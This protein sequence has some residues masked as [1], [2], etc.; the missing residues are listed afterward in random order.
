MINAPPLKT[1]DEGSIS[2]TAAAPSSSLD[3]ARATRQLL[4]AQDAETRQIAARA[5]AAACDNWDDDNKITARDAILPLAKMLRA[6]AGEAE[7]GALA[8]R[9]MA[10]NSENQILIAK[11][12]A[13]PP[14]VALLQNGTDVAKENAAGA[15]MFIA[16]R[17][18]NN[19]VA[20][21]QAGAI[22]PLVALLQ[23]GTDKMQE[24][25]AETLGYLAFCD[26]DNG[27]KNKALIAKGVAISASIAKAGAILPL[28]ALLKNGTDGT[29]E[30]A[31]GA[32]QALADF[33][34]DNKV[35]IVSA[36]AIPLLVAL[37]QNGYAITK[38]KAAGLLQYLA[39]DDDNNKV[40]IVSA[41]AIQPL[42]ALL[43][44]GTDQMKECAAGTLGDLAY[45]SDNRVSI[46][47]AGAIP[48]LVE[49][50][51]DGTLLAQE[52]AEWAL[53]TLSD[54]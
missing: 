16:Y 22:P 18:D 45:D 3:V 23:N 51:Q 54:C 42:V 27:S 4:A 13:I 26:L 9:K 17:N 34:D 7:A 49:L 20:I 21:A 52:N 28:V 24:I 31:V 33:N 41:G 11:A 30:C 39:V 29:K 10:R 35:P 44:N 40:S 5:V 6:S 38:E 48:P 19:K 46:A 37:L 12:G 50:L 15:L 1:L 8:L 47:R 2:L 25:A 36:G 32:L 53:S 43:Q 14:L